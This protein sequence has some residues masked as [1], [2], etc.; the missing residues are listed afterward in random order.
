M[1]DSFLQHASQPWLG[2][3]NECEV[4]IQDN[5]YHQHTAC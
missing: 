1:T 3:G 4:L 5:F 2:K